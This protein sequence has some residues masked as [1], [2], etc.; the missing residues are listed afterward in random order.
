MLHGRGVFFVVSLLL[1][2]HTLVLLFGLWSAFLERCCPHGDPMKTSDTREHLQAR[3]ACKQG[4]EETMADTKVHDASNKVINSTRQE[5][6]RRASM[7]WEVPPI[8]TIA[9][10]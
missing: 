4:K 10:T 7:D 9:D 5:R 3:G 8:K 1:V 2:L 6:E